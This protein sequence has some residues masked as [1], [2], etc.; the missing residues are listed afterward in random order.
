MKYCINCGEKVK[1]FIKICPSCGDVIDKPVASNSFAS[2]SNPLGSGA[3]NTTRKFEDFEV[4][5]TVSFD[6]EDSETSVPAK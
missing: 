1:S 3:N 5:A 4:D 2:N 6:S